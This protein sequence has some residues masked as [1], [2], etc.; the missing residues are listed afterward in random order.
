M[1]GENNFGGFLKMEIKA[2]FLGTGQRKVDVPTS[3]Q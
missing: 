3:Q 1:R 2:E